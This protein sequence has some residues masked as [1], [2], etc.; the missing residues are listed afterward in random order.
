[1]KK[2]LIVAKHTVKDARKLARKHGVKRLRLIRTGEFDLSFTAPY[3]AEN[4]ERV[5]AWFAD[6][7]TDLK[8]PFAPG[9]CLWHTTIN[10]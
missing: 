9:A 6:A 7:S 5:R 1:M 4:D 8:A 10:E 2:I 3:T